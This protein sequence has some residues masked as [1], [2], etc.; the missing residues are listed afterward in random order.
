MSLQRI[1]IN[2]KGY[3]LLQQIMMHQCAPA[4]FLEPPVQ[5]KQSHSFCNILSCLI[6]GILT[7]QTFHS[8]HRKNEAKLSFS[9]A[10]SYTQH[11]EKLRNTD[12]VKITDTL[13]VY[14]MVEV[15][16]VF[17]GITFINLFVKLYNSSHCSDLDWSFQA[18]TKLLCLGEI[19]VEVLP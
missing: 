1:C 8:L 13:D 2:Q 4:L 11:I 9:I 10:F 16:L 6:C 12:W 17:T 14:D 19:I 18:V 3:L 5:W 7:Y 15:F